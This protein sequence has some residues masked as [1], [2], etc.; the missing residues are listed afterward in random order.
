[1]PEQEEKTKQ[2]ENMH[3][4]RTNKNLQ[5]KQNCVPHPRFTSNGP[6]LAL[7]FERRSSETF[8]L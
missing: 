1:M 2:T 5:P 4:W 7:P 3:T 6:S 8:S